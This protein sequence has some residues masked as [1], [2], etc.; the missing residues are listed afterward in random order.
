MVDAFT[1]RNHYNPCFWTA[2]WNEDYF[3]EYCS[4]TARGSSPRDQVVY[5]L[6]LHA[7]KVLRTTVEKVHFHK[8]LGVAEIDPESARRFC[9]ASAD[10]GR[11]VPW[12]FGPPSCIS[13]RGTARSPRLR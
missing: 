13:T 11:C 9:S 12:N 1:R 5:A 4:D 6:N 3:R 10:S 8:D 2:L 7:A